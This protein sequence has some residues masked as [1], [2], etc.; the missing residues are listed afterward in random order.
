MNAAA[1]IFGLP[2]AALAV[3]LIALAAVVTAKLIRDRRPAPLRGRVTLERV[4]AEQQIDHVCTVTGVE[5]APW[6]RDFLVSA[7]LVPAES[8]AAA[9]PTAAAHHHSLRTAGGAE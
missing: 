2:T 8:A 9:P 6:Q 4:I 3:C 5:L 7:V 1:L